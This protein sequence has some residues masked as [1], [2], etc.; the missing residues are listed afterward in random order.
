M[1]EHTTFLV[2]PEFFG[3]TKTMIRKNKTFKY[4]LG[5]LQASYSLNY[6]TLFSLSIFGKIRMSLSKT[7]P[8]T[9]LLW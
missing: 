6:R 8:I 4:I 2:N 3:K 5:I 1:S 9:L 7:S